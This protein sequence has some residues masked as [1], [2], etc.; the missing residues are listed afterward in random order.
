MWFNYTWFF[1]RKSKQ[2]RGN[3]YKI[4]S[5]T[6]G[7]VLVKTIPARRQTA[8]LSSRGKRKRQ[9]AAAW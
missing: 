7:D 4:V 8:I 3:E 6:D 2:A 1:L 5:N 9:Q